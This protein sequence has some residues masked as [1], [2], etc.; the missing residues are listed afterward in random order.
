MERINYIPPELWFEIFKFPKGSK[1]LY[2]ASCELGAGTS[3]C[4]ATG[5]TDTWFLDY[6]SQGDIYVIIN[7]VEDCYR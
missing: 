5:N 1:D 2:G 3:W 7:T 6:I 4:T